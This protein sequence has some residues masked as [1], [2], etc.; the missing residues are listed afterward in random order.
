MTE[1]TAPRINNELEAFSNRNLFPRAFLV[2]RNMD[3]ILKD[4][5]K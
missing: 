1:T 4:G 3:G 2:K 5:E